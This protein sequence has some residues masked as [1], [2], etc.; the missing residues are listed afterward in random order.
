MGLSP[1]IVRGIKRKG[2]RLP[3]PIQRRAT[4]LILAGHDVVGMA[5][6]GSG[7]TAAFAIPLLNRLQAHSLRAGARGLILSPTRELALQTHRVIRELGRYTDLRVAALV[8]GDALDAQFAE[9]ASNPDILVA[10]PGRLLHMLSEVAGLSLK[11]VQLVVFD[12]ADRL[13]EMGFAAQLRALLGALPPDRQALLFSATLPA[14]LAEFA[15]AGLKDPEFVR[16]DADAKLSPDLSTAF[17]TVRD[18]D[19]PAAL[20]WLVREVLP[21]RAP[22]AVFCSTRH[23]VEFVAALLAATGSVDMDDVTGYPRIAAVHGS[24][25]Q[26][27]RTIA[28][29]RFRA[30][31]A[32]VLV[33]TD[34]AARGLDLPHLDAVINYDFPPKPKLF[35][36]RA[37]R[38]ARAGRAG[39][40]WSLASRDEV[41]YVL[42]LHLFLGRPLAVAP[43]APLGL[44]AAGAAGA[45]A[46]GATLLGAVPQSALDTE[47]EQIRA[48]MANRGDLTSLAASADNAGRLYRRTRPPCASESAARAKALGQPGPHPM[49]AAAMPEGAAAAAADARTGGHAAGAAA[50]ITAALRAYRPSATVLEASVAPSA[51]AARAGQG[52]GASAGVVFAAGG[53]T[54]DARTADVMRAKRKAHSAAIAGTRAGAVNDAAIDAARARGPSAATVSA[55]DAPTAAARLEAARRAAQLAAEVGDG[56]FA[57]GAEDGAGPLRFREAGFFVPTVKADAAAEAGFSVGGGGE[58]GG[59][60]GN[61]LLGGA[62]LDLMADDEAG[63]AAGARS[64]SKRWHWDAKARKYVRLQA[65]ESVRAGKRV[66]A[67]GASALATPGSAGSKKRRAESGAAYEKWARATRLRVAATGEAEGEAA[68]RLASSDLAGRFKKGG[69]GWVNPASSKHKK[70]SDFGER[71]GGGRGPRD[72]VKSADQMR[73]DRRRIEKE[74]DRAA[75]RGG[76]SNVRGGRGGG[77][78]GGGGRGGGGRGGGGRGGGG[79]GGGRGNSR[80]GSGRGRG[81]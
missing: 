42:D 75:Q 3:T 23:H 52:A 2:Y 19:R 13:F 62:V 21:R 25:D 66:R 58:A 40:A 35:V 24:M 53:T 69:R 44:A 68:G 65:D 26:A 74:R 71:K 78:R 55:L 31:R 47:A 57:G 79:R 43:P 56:D 20:A 12:E 15:G 41:G 45:D 50:D 8:G 18:E 60:G 7:K 61:A 6:T 27:A 30:G 33:V 32:D 51:A 77:G 10:T 67:G 76:G 73:A 22:T 80:G 4:P 39:S 5:R 1:A 48:L 49:L 54:G 29:G 14:A 46:G 36:H 64:G 37:G 9:L 59:L 16:L 70:A 34:V 28:V 38:A 63:M 72:E 81:R 17:F 11:A